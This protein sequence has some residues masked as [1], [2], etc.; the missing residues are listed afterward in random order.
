MLLLDVSTFAD[1]ITLLRESDRVWKTLRKELYL[2]DYVEHPTIEKQATL[3]EQRGRGYSLKG[4]NLPIQS[5]IPANTRSPLAWTS[6]A[7]LEPERV[8]RGHTT[9]LLYNASSI[10]NGHNVET[11]IL[12]IA[13]ADSKRMH[14]VKTAAQVFLDSLSLSWDNVED[15]LPVKHYFHRLASGSRLQTWYHRTL[16]RVQ[17]KSTVTLR[18]VLEK[19]LST[20]P[21]F[22]TLLA[23]LPAKTPIHL[24]VRACQRLFDQTIREI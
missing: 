19:A 12:P 16:Y 17:C 10:Q 15:V 7:G 9:N 23:K 24:V 21:L 2:Q 5:K 8:T 20:R 18:K 11:E 6:S 22:R 3:L 1:S 14:E 4:V 13:S